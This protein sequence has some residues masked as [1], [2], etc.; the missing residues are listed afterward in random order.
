MI[1]LRTYVS[2]YLR[3][4]YRRFYLPTSN[5]PTFPPLFFFFNFFGVYWPIIWVHFTQFHFPDIRCTA[6]VHTATAAHPLVVAGPRSLP[7]HVCTPRKCPRLYRTATINSSCVYN[8]TSSA[9]WA[10]HT[11]QHLVQ[12]L[13]G[14][15]QYKIRCFHE[16]IICLSAWLKTRSRTASALKT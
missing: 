13:I 4:I 10:Y 16:E 3:L 9:H 2:T 8:C 12:N 15:Y 7:S 1:N 14:T 11:A 5:L 6:A